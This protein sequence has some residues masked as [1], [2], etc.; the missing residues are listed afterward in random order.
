MW[1]EKKMREEW[2]TNEAIDDFVQ[3]IQAWGHKEH[4][5]S[6]A[7]AEQVYKSYER[8]TGTKTEIER[9]DFRRAFEMG[10]RFAMLKRDTSNATAHVR[11][12][13]SN[14]QQIVGKQNGGT[15]HECE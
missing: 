8:T 15:D 14:V 6:F 1:D 9:F 4:N 3:R 12:V 10:Y 5:E 7:L 2:A 13:A 11:A